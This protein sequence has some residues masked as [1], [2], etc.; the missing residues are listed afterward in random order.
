MAVSTWRG[1]VRVTTFQPRRNGVSLE[2]NGVSAWR[3]GVTSRD[4][5]TPGPC[6]VVTSDVIGQSRDAAEVSQT[7]VGV[8]RLALSQA[9][10][11]LARHSEFEHPIGQ[12]TV[13]MF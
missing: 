1:C 8:G 10:D 13:S 3:D 5:V 9:V 12:I 2:R 4:G 6:N 11:Q 7:R